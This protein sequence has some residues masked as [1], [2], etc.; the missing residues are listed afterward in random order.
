M[1]PGYRHVPSLATVRR[2]LCTI[3]I[4]AV[5]AYLQG[6][7]GK[8]GE[9]GQI[10][11]LNSERLQGQAVDGKTLRGASAHQAAQGHCT[12]LVAVVRHEDGLVLSQASTQAKLDESTQAQALLA[13]LP[14]KQTVT[15][16]DALHTSRIQAVQIRRQGGHYLFVVKRNQKTLHADIDA[17]FSVLPPQGIC[18]VDFWQYESCALT[19][20]SHGRS[21]QYRLESIPALNDFVAFPD[22]AQ[23]VRR[24]GIAQTLCTDSRKGQPRLDQGGGRL[25]MAFSGRWVDWANGFRRAIATFHPQTTGPK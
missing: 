15:T 3:S 6:L 5:G 10:V 1:Q 21:V 11:M 12:H 23:L 16:F 25:G 7:Q 13:A 4:E 22:V 18:E 2:V 14:L 24:T 8:M 20:R 19:E 9:S 17:A